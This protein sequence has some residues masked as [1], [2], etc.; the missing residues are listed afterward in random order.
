M[1][2]SKTY[3][4]VFL[5]LV[6]IFNGCASRN[7]QNSNYIPP[8]LAVIDSIYDDKTITNLF[9]KDMLIVTS[10]STKNNVSIKTTDHLYLV[11]EINGIP[12]TPLVEE[13]KNGKSWLLIASKIG[14][15]Q[16]SIS[17]YDEETKSF[18]EKTYYITVL[19]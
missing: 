18:Y 4:M 15:G 10:N 5:F 9:L 14:T 12:I 7:S 1:I 19:Q 13:K 3:L 16:C 8:T 2:K 11:C 17:V 6:G